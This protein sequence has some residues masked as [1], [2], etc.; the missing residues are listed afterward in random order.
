M[1]SPWSHEQLQH[2]IHEE[3]AAVVYAETHERRRGPAAD[4]QDRAQEQVVPEPDVPAVVVG[5]DRSPA[6]DTAVAW[7]AAEAVRRGGR[8]VLVRAEGLADLP[9]PAAQWDE[10]ERRLDALAASVRD[11]HPSL[12]DVA[13]ELLAGAAGPVLVVRAADAD[14]LV[15]GSHGRGAVSRAVLGSTSAY[16]AV[17]ATVPTVVVPRAWSERRRS[18]A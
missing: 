9:L 5:V 10:E 17:H 15:V 13:S 8:L 2:A 16:C 18:G 3:V 6:S 1:S 14:L 11:A 12:E 7:A 4:E